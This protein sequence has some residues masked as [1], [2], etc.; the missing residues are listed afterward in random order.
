MFKDVGPLA[1]ALIYLAQRSIDISDMAVLMASETRFDPLPAPATWPA[2]FRRNRSGQSRNW[3]HIGTAASFTV[4]HLATPDAWAS[5]RT[6]QEIETDLEDGHVVLLIYGLR[7]S[8][9][10]LVTSILIDIPVLRVELHDVPEL[11]EP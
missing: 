8:L 7:S 3:V 5:V 10:A 4:R 11:R 6:E 2:V 9:Q 1:L